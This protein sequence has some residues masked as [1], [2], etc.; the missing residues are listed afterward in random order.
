MSLRVIAGELK[1]RRL[2]TASGL[3]TRPTAER[4]RE[5]IFSIL[6][7]AVRHTHVLDLFA[8]TGAY[9]IEALSRGAASALFIEVDRGACAALTVNIQTCGMAGK[10]RVLRWDASRNLNCL[11]N[12]EPPFQLVFM[13]P[14]YGRGLV[15]PALSHLHHARCASDGAQLV[16]EHGQDD[17][18]PEPALPYRLQDRRRYGRTL[19]SFLTYVL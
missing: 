4:T 9:G 11:R 17:P 2:R 1:G 7:S 5:A 6:G 12:H 13:D 3:R 15:E 18:L 19:V 10:A 8:G 14:P 16:V